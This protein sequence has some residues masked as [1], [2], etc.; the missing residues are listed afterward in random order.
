MID[1]TTKIHGHKID[2][3]GDRHVFFARDAF[4]VG[5]HAVGFRSGENETKL[6][7]SDEAMK[8]LVSLYEDPP[9]PAWKLL[10]NNVEGPLW[11]RVTHD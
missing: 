11:K 2:L 3:P 8:A 10:A 7:V 4:G 5:T 9:E 1:Q 6:T